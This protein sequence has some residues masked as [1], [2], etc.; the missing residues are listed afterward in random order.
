MDELLK[1]TYEA[2]RAH[3]WYRGFRRF[4]EPFLARAVQGVSHPRILDCGCGTGANLAM[5]ATYGHDFGFDLAGDGVAYAAAAGHRRIARA[6]VA[7][8]PFPDNS[9]DVATS[10]DVLYC[11]EDEVERAALDEMFRVVRPGGA[12]VANV[13]AM[14][15]LTGDHSVFVGERRRYS[16]ARLGS[17]LARAGFRVARITHTNASI[18]LPMLGVRVLQRARGTNSTPTA[19]HDFAIPPALINALLSLLLSAEAGV[20]RLV[21]LPLGSSI[22][23][24]A[25]KPAAE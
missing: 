21:D 23:C 2:E 6:T 13:P 19:R 15:V 4:V 14:K 11:L 16:R 22:L 12:L 20:L 18:F 9:F 10:F 17:A 1:A 25:R 24:L 8:L 7:H 3:F 5:L